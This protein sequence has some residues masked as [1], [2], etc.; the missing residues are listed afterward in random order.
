MSAT[1]QA[2]LQAR[3]QTLPVFNG[4]PDAVTRGDYRIL[5]SGLANMIV[6][7][8]GTFDSGDNT[9]FERTRTWDIPFDVV[10][11][12]LDSSSACADLTTLRDDVL[13]LMDGLSVLDDEGLVTFRRLRSDGDPEE[14]LDVQRNPCFLMQTLRAEIVEVVR[15]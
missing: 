10:V 1:I 4:H 9:D 15:D 11:K 5:D 12:L 7:L 8:P 14:V 13:D 3:L 2:L 6:I